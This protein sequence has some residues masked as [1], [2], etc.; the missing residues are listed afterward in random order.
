MRII[1]HE[2][3]K[4]HPRNSIAYIN[5]AKV[6]KIRKIGIYKP[7]QERRFKVV[8]KYIHPS[9][10]VDDIKKILKNILLTHNH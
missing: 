10:N 2:K 9:A 1:N 8:L 7:K 5:I 6:F 3:I 4:I